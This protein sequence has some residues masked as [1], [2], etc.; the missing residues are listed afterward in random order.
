MTPMLATPNFSKPFLVECDASGHGLGAVLMQEGRPIAFESRKLNKKD[1]GRS[2]YKKEMLAILHSI[3]KWHQY[4]LGNHFKV[5]INHDSLKYFLEKRVSSKEQQKWVSMI[6][7][8]DFKIIYKKGKENVVADALSR[9]EEEPSLNSLSMVD[10]TWINEVRE[11]WKQDPEAQQLIQK[12]K[13]GDG[14]SSPFS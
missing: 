14:D 13:Q 4:L 10:P 5:K 7:G 9:R 3:R 1:L 8:F 6:Q 11:E 2:T 12:M